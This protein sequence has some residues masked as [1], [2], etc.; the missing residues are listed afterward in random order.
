MILGVFFYK[1]DWNY[2]FSVMEQTANDWRLLLLEAQ[3]ADIAL[4]LFGVI[5][6]QVVEPIQMLRPPDARRRRRGCTGTRAFAS[7]IGDGVAQLGAQLLD[8]I[9]ARAA[10]TGAA[11]TRGHRLAVEIMRALQLKQA[12]GQ[13]VNSRCVKHDLNFTAPLR[14]ALIPARTRLIGRAFFVVFRRRIAAPTRHAL[15]RR[16]G[17]GFAGENGAA[18]FGF[19]RRRRLTFDLVNARFVPRHRSAIRALDRMGRARKPLVTA[20]QTRRLLALYNRRGGGI[21]RGFVRFLHHGFNL[22][23]TRQWR[24]SR[25]GRAVFAA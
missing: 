21:G 16:L 17:C 5:A 11:K 13:M 12:L 8:L 4:D 6:Q 10:V 14:L 20:T 22:N 24:F 1:K 18:R 25:K 9:G 23:Y 15:R 7:Q 3:N 2:W 19:T